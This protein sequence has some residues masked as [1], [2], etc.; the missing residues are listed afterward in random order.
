MA[1]PEEIK[2][3]QEYSF[4]EE[5]IEGFVQTMQGFIDGKTTAQSWEEIEEDLN[6]TYGN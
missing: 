6:R 2:D 5:E 4:S 1:K 3:D